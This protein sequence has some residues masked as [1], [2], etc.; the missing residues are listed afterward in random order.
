METITK[1]LLT[2]LEDTK[3]QLQADTNTLTITDTQSGVF[4]TLR[5]KNFSD[6][7]EERRFIKNVERLI[8]SSIEYKE[9]VFFVKDSLHLDICAFTGESDEETGDIEIHHHPLTLYDIVQ[10]VVDTY[11]MQ[12]QEF[13][14]F[15]IAQEVIDLHFKLKVGFV[16]L[17]GSLHKKFHNGYLDIPIDVV[18]GDYKYIL[19]HYYIR[20]EVKEKVQKYESI[21]LSSRP[22]YTWSKDFY[23]QLKVSDNK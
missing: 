6:S 19:Q 2:V 21:T 10:A 14:S 4:L 12:D 22:S 20:D 5:R 8:R 16:P 15:E 11:V 3:Q 7:T 17:L 23:P 13:C 9:W 18:H 1:D